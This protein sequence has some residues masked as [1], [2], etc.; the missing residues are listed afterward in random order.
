MKDL[1]KRF[2]NGNIGPY[3]V[4]TQTNPLLLQPKQHY[5]QP[6]YGYSVNSCLTQQQQQATLEQQRQQ[7]LQHASQHGVQLQS[8]SLAQY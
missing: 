8:N 1:S 5:D 6:L 3:S 4:P 7:H 2:L